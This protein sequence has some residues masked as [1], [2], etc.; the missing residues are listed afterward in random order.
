MSHPNF[1]HPING[2]DSDPEDVPV[3]VT[4]P[5]L[6]RASRSLKQLAG[7]GI[8]LWTSVAVAAVAVHPQTENLSRLEQLLVDRQWQA[9]SDATWAMIAPDGQTSDLQQVS[10]DL[11]LEVDHL[12][13][14]ASSGQFGFT[15]QSRV[16]QRLVTNPSD[17][18]PN[19]DRTDHFRQRVGW[20]RFAPNSPEAQNSKGYFPSDR[21][22]VTGKVLD[23]GCGDPT[24]STARTEVKEQVSAVVEVFPALDRCLQ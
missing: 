23:F 13:T 16:W 4:S 22:L 10:C 3:W 1:L 19:P 20:N 7:I 8:L 5:N 24:C 17:S 18:D 11:L 2:T 21:P 12:W 6:A 9:A 15:A 14:Q